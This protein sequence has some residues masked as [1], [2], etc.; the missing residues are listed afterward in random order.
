MTS[1][2][3]MT[4]TLAL[5]LTALCA[6]MLLSCETEDISINLV[7]VIPLD[8]ESCDTSTTAKGDP[9]T[10]GAFDL[11]LGTSYSL[12]LS[13]SNAL[14]N[15][16]AAKELEDRDG[17]VNT[18]NINLTRLS[19]EYIDADGVDLGLD[20]I[21]DIPL[22]GQLSTDAT[23]PLVIPNVVVFTS[24]MT[25]ILEQNGVL[26]G[27]GLTGPVPVRG[28][29]TVILQLTLFGETVDQKQ[30]QS[31]KVNFPVEVCT[32]CR[33]RGTWEDRPLTEEETL[34]L[35]TCPNSIGKD[36]EFASCALCQALAKPELIQLCEP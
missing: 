28:S 16:V 8:P 17:R 22:A 19:V 33:V 25:E 5:S 3:Y 26:K 27:T 9:V 2:K 12:N 35:S 6:S 21:V 20:P 14:L 32:G 24:Q 10:S 23:E 13:A 7:K 1:R 4:P 29:F 11:V 31:N 18:N 15:V 34:L 36:T 30:V